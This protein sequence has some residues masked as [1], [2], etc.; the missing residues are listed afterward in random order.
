MPSD[1]GTP[2]TFLQVYTLDDQAAAVRRG[3]IV[4]GLDS[5]VLH[6]LTEMLTAVNPYV[7][8]FKA[9]ANNTT[10][11]ARLILQGATSARG[12]APGG[13]D[14][15]T[16]SLPMASEVAVLITGADDE[17]QHARE[18]IVHKVVGEPGQ[19]YKLQYI[20]TRCDTSAS[21]HRL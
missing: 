9:L 4:S 15:R 3:S 8:H 20:P 18:V 11:N 19:G 7:G 16:Y 12:T 10:P 1:D 2:R 21:R 6:N 14:A 17:P 5:N 13:Q